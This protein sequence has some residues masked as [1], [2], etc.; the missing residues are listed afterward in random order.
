[1][2][3]QYL[4]IKTRHR[5]AIMFFRL[6]D[7]YEMFFED[8]LVASP[9]LEIALTAR[10]GGK[11]KIPMCGIPHHAYESYAAK[12]LGKGYKVAICEQVEDP[13]Q[14]KGIVQREVTRIITPGTIID[15]KIL[16]EKANNY[17]VAIAKSEDCWGLAY[18][19]ISTGEFKATQST[20]TEVSVLEELNRLKPAETLLFNSLRGETLLIETLKQ[21][22][23][24]IGWQSNSAV[25]FNEE[26]SFLRGEANK[27]FE[28][29]EELFHWPLATKAAYLVLKFLKE[30]QKQSLGN[31]TKLEIYKP[32]NFMLFDGATRRNL[33]LSENLHTKTVRGSLLGVL[34]ATGTSMGARKLKQWLE[35]PLVDL[36]QIK[37]RLD[38]VEELMANTTLREKLRLK[39]KGIYDL[40]RLLGRI[41]YGT[42]NARDLLALKNS[43]ARLPEI[44]ELL[45]FAKSKNLQIHYEGFDLLLD[46]YNLL[47][48]SILDEVPT[49]TR[50]GN[51]I[52]EGFHP[53]ADKLR[54]ASQEGKQ[55]IAELEAREKERTGIRSLKVGYNKVFGYYIE[56]TKSNLNLIPED[57]NRKQTLANAERFTIV[58]LKEMESLILGAEEKLNNLEYELFLEICL[59]IKD[60]SR[61]IQRSANIVAELD[62]YLSLATVALN[63]N[64]CKP[65]IY[66]DLKL[67][68]IE[69]RHPVVE[70]LVE[71]SFVG[72][73]LIL[74]PP[75][76]ILNVITGPNMAGKS[77]YI[78]TAALIGVMAQMGSFVPASSA[79]IGVLDRIFARVGAS[80]DLSKGQ[81]TF[82]V[83]MNEVAHILNHATKKSLIILDEV[84]RGTSTFDGISIA[85]AISEYIIEKIQA[86]TLFATHYHE[87]AA[88]EEKYQ[89]V[90]N[91]SMS[92]KED[93]ETITFL[94]KVV[95]GG[96]DRSYGIHVAELAGLPME[97]ISVAYAILNRLEND[98]RKRKE[99]RILIKPQDALGKQQD[100]YN[101]VKKTEAFFHDVTK[102]NPDNITPIEALHLLINYRLGAEK[103]LQ[104]IRE[105]KNESNDQSP[106]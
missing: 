59:Q 44:Y 34:D 69:A 19:D 77:T 95:P 36:A 14:A 64:Y 50:D 58:E 106:L 60:A 86:K 1:M 55:W 9:I 24:Y 62:T 10:D 78:R 25:T 31:L 45:G 89:E 99:T 100:Y 101:L 30:T 65:E 103:L 15:E 75:L 17:L 11:S 94:R 56:V 27:L 105:E 22:G 43:I 96:T 98:K 97:V 76:K 37:R 16:K 54:M 28:I 91:F 26:I 90:N 51:F 102:T 48:N 72:N 49:S 35:A 74:N 73:D 79:K 20:E 70:Q 23:S 61:R 104:A 2:I 53:E 39:I 6:G 71:D 29:E 12:L 46:I 83:E 3:Q 80:D 81:S 38:A 84:G 7:F 33:E 63:N 41:S 68:L 57:Y 88:L 4:K 32:S 21:F 87:L 92:V 5:D 8:A 18:T 82:M 13:S 52:K 47:E 85:W 66:S 93:G 42:A 67:E 40:E